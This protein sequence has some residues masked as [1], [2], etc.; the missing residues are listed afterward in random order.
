[1]KPSLLPHVAVSERPFFDGPSGSTGALDP[2]PVLLLVLTFRP[3]PVD[4]TLQVD[5]PNLMDFGLSSA[6]HTPS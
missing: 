5:W 1:M 3:E 2:K 6:I 4:W